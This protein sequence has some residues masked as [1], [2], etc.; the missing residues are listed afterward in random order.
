MKITLLI[1]LGQH[2]PSRRREIRA[3]PP[4]FFHLVPNAGAIQGGLIFHWTNI[5]RLNYHIS[6]AI[7]QDQHAIIPLIDVPSFIYR[8]V[9]GSL[10]QNLSPK[11]LVTQLPHRT[12]ATKYES[13]DV[14]FWSV[15][16][17]SDLKSSPSPCAV[18]ASWKTSKHLRCG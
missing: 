17:D 11:R 1:Y 14:T 2:F 3:L 7:S 15:E 5:N 13:S 12:S 18:S 8:G 4:P 16:H 10:E 9:V 6:R